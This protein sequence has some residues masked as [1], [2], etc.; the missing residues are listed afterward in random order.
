VID[1]RGDVG[2]ALVL[3][4]RTVDGHVRDAKLALLNATVYVALVASYAAVRVVLD[5]PYLRGALG[6]HLA[7]G[8]LA[9]LV[10]VR[11]VP[12]RPSWLAGATAAGL[13]VNGLV[14]VALVAINRGTLFAEAAAAL[15][16]VGLT[17][18]L[19]RVALAR[20]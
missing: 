19:D 15:A 10:K 4:H 9:V 16:A 20:A 18:L 7:I 6:L 8:L 3:D 13:L 17:H 12:Q 1:T 14:L 11:I 2:P 5:V